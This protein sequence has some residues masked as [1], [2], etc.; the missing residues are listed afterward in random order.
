MDNGWMHIIKSLSCILLCNSYYSN[1]VIREQTSTKY[2]CQARAY[3][4]YHTVL[5]HQ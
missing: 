2:V 3:D 4:E 1:T 5:N